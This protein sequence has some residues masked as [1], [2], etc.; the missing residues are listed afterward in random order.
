[1]T[2]AH[3]LETLTRAVGDTACLAGVALQLA[4]ADDAECRVHVL[5]AQLRALNMQALATHRQSDDLWITAHHAAQKGDAA[6]RTALDSAVDLV[7][8]LRTAAALFTQDAQRAG[9]SDRV[10][11]SPPGAVR[12]ADL[13]TRAA[14][15][16]ATPASTGGAGHA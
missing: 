1:M 16:L 3:E 7:D 15:A 11:L 2:T 9:D 6:M 13:L 4:I 14:D 10:C 5:A 8:E 12:L